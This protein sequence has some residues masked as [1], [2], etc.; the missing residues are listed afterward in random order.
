MTN[1][2][3]ESKIL[4]NPDKECSIGGD[5]SVLS[6][7]EEERANK[8]LHK[9]SKLIQIMVPAMDPAAFLND[10]VKMIFDRNLPKIKTA[11][12]EMED[13]SWLD[14]R[15]LRGFTPLILTTKLA[16]VDQDTYYQ[17]LLAL[18]EAGANPRAKDSDGWTALEEAISHGNVKFCSLLF[19]YVSA[20][21]LRTLADHQ[22]TL[23]DDLYQLQDYELHVKWEFDSSIIPLVSKIGPSDTF[24]IWKVGNRVR[25]D[26]TIAG[27]KNLSTKRRPMC[28][29]SSKAAI[30]FNPANAPVTRDDEINPIKVICINHAKKDFFD[31]L[32]DVDLEEKRAIINDLLNSAPVQGRFDLKKHSIEESRSIFG[33]LQTKE[34][35]GY[36]AKK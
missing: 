12:C 14:H 10:I 30:L 5:K 32:E 25:L 23:L 16:Y 1:H 33:N 28:V 8:S 11:L 29:A 9:S 4:F 35:Q 7:A 26:S 15:D 22:Q 17:I 2:N 31:P 18:L 27:Y 3:M 6:E 34:I 21:K 19:D 24:K 13:P 20:F 36:E